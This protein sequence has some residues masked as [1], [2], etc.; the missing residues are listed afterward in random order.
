MPLSGGTK[1]GFAGSVAAYLVAA[2]HLPMVMD[3]KDHFAHASSQPAIVF[4][5]SFRFVEMFYPLL[6]AGFGAAVVWKYRRAKADSLVWFAVCCYVLFKV[7]YNFLMVHPWHQSDWYYAFASLSLSLMGAVAL[8]EPWRRLEGVPLV[9]AGIVTVYG[10]VL[11]LTGSQYFASIAYQP[12][13][14][15]DILFWDR[16]DGLRAELVQHG[17]TGLINVDDGITAFLLDFPTMH[18]FAFATDVEAQKAHRTATMLT[19]AQARGIN[20]ITGFQYLAADT[21][22]QTD[23]EIREYLKAPLAMESVRGDM[24]KFD[25]KLAYYD[26]VLKMPFITFTPKAN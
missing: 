20:T 22:P 11:L 2:V 15:P 9:K 23:A 18:G 8:A 13:T 6:L 21:P 5:N 3:L 25:F 19:L 14:T 12:A 24:D 1:S 10:C 17:V 7:G 26:P 16:A 4:A